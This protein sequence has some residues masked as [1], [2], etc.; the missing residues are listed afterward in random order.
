MFVRTAAFLLIEEEQA[1]QW[2]VGLICCSM[3]AKMPA[4]ASTSPAMP[5]GTSPARAQA[6]KKK[7]TRKA[8]T[9][10]GSRRRKTTARTS[11]QARSQKPSLGNMSQARNDPPVGTNLALAGKRPG[12]DCVSEWRKA[13]SLHW[14][15]QRNANGF[16]FCAPGFMKCWRSKPRAN[17]ANV[18]K[19]LAFPS[20][21]PGSSS[22]VIEPARS[23]G[24]IVCLP[25]WATC[26]LHTGLFL[27]SVEQR[28]VAGGALA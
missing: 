3:P 17:F 9:R 18:P 11:L 12:F 24:A 7:K 27:H 25:L 4:K 14:T 15:G 26:L 6:P 19:I 2:T 10:K 20:T 23:A 1:E 5:G 8:D 22:V 13:L 16:Q 21:R 28:Q